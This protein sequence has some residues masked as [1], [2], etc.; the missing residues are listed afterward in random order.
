MTELKS[1]Y[2]MKHGVRYLVLTEKRWKAIDS[3]FKRRD[4]KNRLILR[5]RNDSGAMVEDFV[6]VLSKEQEEILRL[7][8][9][10]RRIRESNPAALGLKPLIGKLYRLMYNNGYHRKGVSVL[11]DDHSR[12]RNDLLSMVEV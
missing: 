10:S 5:H 1:V 8:T 2:V 9:Q 4:G 12:I 3:C 6:L 11:L 7:E